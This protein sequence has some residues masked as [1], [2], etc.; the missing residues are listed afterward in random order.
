MCVMEAK[1]IAK[2]DVQN[3]EECEEEFETAV[4]RRSG[5]A[6]EMEAGQEAKWEIY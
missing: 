5:L 3:R 4:R 1:E 6:A 2:W